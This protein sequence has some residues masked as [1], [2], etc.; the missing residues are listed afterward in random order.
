MAVKRPLRILVTGAGGFVG[1]ALVRVLAADHQVIATDQ[2]G[3]DFDDLPGVTCLPGD[4]GDPAVIMAATAQPADVVIHLATVPGG[5][6][7]AQPAL[8]SHINITASMALIDAA[9]MHGNRP[10]I[11]YASSIAVFGNPLPGHVNDDTPISPVLRYG[12]HKAMMEEW[13]ATLTRRGD[14]SG[15]SLRLPGIIARPQGPSGMKSAF[16]SDLFHALK[17]G[18]PITLPVSPDA[19]CWL[20]S[21]AVL[22]EQIRKAIALP[23]D[24]EDT[25]L[26]LPALRVQMGGLVDEVAQQTGSDAALV[27]YAPDPGIEAAFGNQPPLATPRANALGLHHDGTLADLVRHALSD[28]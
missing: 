4:L 25:R 15:L 12:A 5:A 1:R 28:I 24:A 22:V 6:A 2:A 9:A 11:I 27:T 21:R 7:E 17:A 10:R 3:L 23:G 14:I 20:L 16:M 8:A 26:N 18:A 19:T 13:I